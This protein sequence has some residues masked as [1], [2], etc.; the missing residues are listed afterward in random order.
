M[1]GSLRSFQNF[2]GRGD[3]KGLHR[4]KGCWRVKGRLDLEEGFV[5]RGAGGAISMGECG[6]VLGRLCTSCSVGLCGVLGLMKPI[7]WFREGILSRR[8]FFILFS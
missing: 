2:G 8:E 6:R 7:S 4:L 3:L 5:I 1:V